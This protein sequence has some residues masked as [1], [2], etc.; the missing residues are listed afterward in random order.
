MIALLRL[1]NES[2]DF[3]SIAIDRLL[4]RNFS[5]GIDVRDILSDR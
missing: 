4:L 5:D 1:N 2:L 3:P